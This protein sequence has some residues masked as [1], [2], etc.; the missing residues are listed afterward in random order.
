[1]TAEALLLDLD[2]TLVDS[3]ESITRSWLRWTEEFRVDPALLAEAHGRTSAAIVADLVPADRVAEAL[4]RIDELEVDDAGTVRAMGGVPDWLA[5]LPS[6]AWAIVTSGHARLARA[7]IA[8][9]GVPSPGVL[10]TADDIAHGKPHPEPFLLGAARLGVEPERCV[11]LEDAPS[12]IA[13]ARA[14]GMGVVA[15]TSNY[16]AAKLDADLHVSSPS[17]LRVDGAGP[18]RLSLPAT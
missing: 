16:P 6:A 14:A 5:A 9:S 13:A 3:S 12:G 10:V 4:A 11:V 15:V 7:R 8:A 2:G 18:L 17:Q 1:M